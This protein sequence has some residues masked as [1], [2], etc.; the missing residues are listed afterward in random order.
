M[1]CN[2]CIAINFVRKYQFCNGNIYCN[3]DLTYIIAFKVNR[4]IRGKFT[5][6][7][8]IQSCLNDFCSIYA[9]C[10]KA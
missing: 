8:E 7:Y 4:T 10:L 9:H 5:P 1:M 3:Q 2:D 6:I